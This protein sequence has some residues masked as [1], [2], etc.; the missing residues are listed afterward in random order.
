MIGPELEA[1]IDITGR[2]LAEMTVNNEAPQVVLLPVANEYY[3][4][5]QEL[6][7]AGRD[8]LFEDVLGLAALM[9]TPR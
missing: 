7:I 3:A 5:R 4:L 8:R 2:G 1:R 9:H 6:S